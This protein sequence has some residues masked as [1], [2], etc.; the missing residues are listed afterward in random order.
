MT[1]GILYIATGEQYIDEAIQS[2][3]S[4]R[5]HMPCTP[6]TLITD[7][8]VNHPGIDSVV[9]K[10]DFR[11]DYGD[12][13]P[14]FEDIPYERTLQLDS[15]TYICDDFSELFDV[16]DNFDFGATINPGVS[17]FEDCHT[18][19]SD[20]V[21]EGFPVFNS[22]VMLY[23]QNE[24]VEALFK[25]W[26]QIYKRTLAENNRKFNQPALWKAL[27]ES[28]I[29][30]FP[31]PREYNCFI[32][33]HGCLSRKAKIV[34]GRHPC[35]KEIATKVNNSNGPRYYNKSKYPINVIQDRFP[36]N[37]QIGYR[38]KLSLD[39]KGIKETVKKA[40]KIIYNND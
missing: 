30:L 21:P 40:I 22:G 16:L 17:H 13:I 7:Q 3:E 29:R 38:I 2:V 15:D 6:V 10:D 8:E 35:Q 4:L 12:S 27:Y 19:I 34:H 32:L 37:E 24:R 14:T 36:G 11:Y 23:E 25:S 18:S 5:S 39:E 28:E 1:C 33:F 31:L 20:S 9:V 26:E